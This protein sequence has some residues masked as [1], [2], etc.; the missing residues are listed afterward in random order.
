MSL[1]LSSVQLYSVREAL[2]NNVRDCLEKLRAAGFDCVEGFD[3]ILLREQKPLL[4]ELGFSV[5]SSFILWSHVTGRH[6]LARAIQYPWMPERWGIEYEIERALSLGL[7]TL[8][9]GYMLP[10]ERQSM[11]DFRRV[12]D[13][14]NK[15]G[16]TCREAGLSLLYHNHAFEFEP[17][18]DLIPYLYLL[19][20]TE[21]ELMGFE[22][23][24]LWAK[25]SGYDPKQLMEK[26]GGRLKQLHLKTSRPVDIPI[27]DDHALGL[28]AHDCPLGEGIVN[29][30]EVV[31]KAESQRVSRVFIEQEYGSDIFTSLKSSLDY[32]NGLK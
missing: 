11:D 6:D 25:L 30:K 7:D 17:R 5:K 15:A 26:L 23:D 22:L 10:E 28:K 3:L 21:P 16:E 13:Q 27:Y 20:N 29:I 12:A 9:F 24:V 31:E 18:D 14:L 2:N 1:N 4:D 8:V 19:E 32:L